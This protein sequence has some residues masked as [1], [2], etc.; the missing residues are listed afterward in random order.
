[1]KWSDTV[2]NVTMA[3]SIVGLKFNFYHFAGQES[4]IVKAFIEKNDIAKI[5]QE[6][7]R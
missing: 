2:I 1:M 6:H 7:L 4:A 5:L 3:N